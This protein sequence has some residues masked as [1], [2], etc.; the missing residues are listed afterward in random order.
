MANP[1]TPQGEPFGWSGLSKT[2]PHALGRAIIRP[3]AEALKYNAFTLPSVFRG[4]VITLFATLKPR[5]K[6]AARITAPVFG[7][8]VREGKPNG[9]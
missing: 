1:R 6:K 4:D 5:L 7:G 9:R 8:E 2:I 3:Q